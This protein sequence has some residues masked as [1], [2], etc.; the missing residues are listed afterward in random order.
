MQEYTVLKIGFFYVPYYPLSTGRSVHGFKLVEGL[1][2][3]GHQI[4]SCLGD[5]NPDCIN[6]E[7]TKWGAIKL[8]RESDVLYIRIAGRPVHSFLEKST[9]L[10]LVR[11]FSLPVVWEVNAPVEELKGSFQAG[12]ERDALIR[13]ENRKRKLLAKLVD[14]GI[15]VSEVLKDY[16]RDSLDIKKAYCIPNASDSRLFEPQNLKESALIHLKN[17]FKVFWMGSANTPWQGVGF[18]IELAKKIHYIDD[19]IVFVIITGES[20]WEFPVLKNL[21]VLREVSYGDLP[22]YLTAADVCLCL[23]KEYDWLEYGFYGS[24]LKLFDYI[25]AGKPIIASDMGQIS[26]II[27]NDNNGL[28]VGNDV[29]TIID[30]IL[31]LKAN[32]EKRKI[33]GNNARNDVINF[34]NWDRVAQQTEAVLMDVCKDKH[35]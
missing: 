29:Q 25:A 2:K 26:T 28:L 14:A 11:P 17:K 13:S 34:Y 31:K 5:G 35:S 4:L 12:A 27:K 32:Q 24:S 21:L 30:T 6:F 16:I 9:L 15:G 19:T 22:H 1:K 33:L 20:L 18:I 7:R 10:K 23:Y 8:A 3:R